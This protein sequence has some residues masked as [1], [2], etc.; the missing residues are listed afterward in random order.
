M[1]I[2]EPGQGARGRALTGGSEAERGRN[3]STQAVLPGGYPVA[4]HQPERHQ[5]G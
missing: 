5:E 2:G 4:M 1:E 3:S